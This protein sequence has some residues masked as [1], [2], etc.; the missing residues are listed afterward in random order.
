VLRALD[1]KLLRD[2]W[3]LKAQAFAIAAVMAAGVTMFLAYISTFSSLQLTQQTYYDRY[4]FAHV[5]AQLTR[6]P[7]SLRE[8][9]V[10][11]PGVS[12]VETRVVADVTLDVPGLVEP[13]IGRLVSIPVPQRAMLNDLFVR[14]G[15]YLEEGRPDEVL[16]NEGFALAHD[17]RPGSTLGA[18]I[19]GRRR[20]LHVAGIALSPEYVYTIRPGEVIPDQKRFGVLWID[21]QALAAAFDMEGGFNDVALTV[22]PGASESTVIAELDQI[23]APYGA[24][25]AVPRRLQISNWALSNEL[26]QLRGFGLIVPVIFLSISAFLL[27]VV[28][29]RIVSVQREQIAA[30]KALGYSNREIGTHYTKWSLLVGLAGAALGIAGGSWM[31]SGMILLYNDFF[32]F[33]LLIFTV[34]PAVIV[35][36]T[37]ISLG[38]ATLGAVGAVARAVRLPPAEAM[39]PEPPA[40]YRPSLV[41]RFGLARLLGPAA[42]MVVRNLERQPVRAMTSIVGIALSSSMLVLGLFFLDAMDEMMRLQFEVIQRQDVTVSFVEPR[43]PAAFFEL[44][45]LPGV[46]AVEPMRVVPVRL[47]A[48]H[49]SRQI[50]ISGLTP[51]PRLQR[52]VNTAGDS[53]ALPPEGLVLSRTLADILEVRA[54]QM[55][56]VE[57]L[58]GRRPVRRVPVV[59]LVDEYLGIAAYM[60]L[61]ALHDLLLEAGTMSGAYLL[62]DRQVESALY[63]RLKAMPAVAGVALKQAAIDSF[64]E[65]MG[66]TMGVMIT[67]NVLFA[68]IIAI[69]VVYNA[70]RVSLSERSRELASL[71]VLGFTRAEISAILLGELAVLTVL[72]IPIG[73]GIGYGLAASVVASFETEMYRFPVVV[74]P[75]TYAFAGAVTAIAAALSGLLVRRRLDRLNLVEVLKTRE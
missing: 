2:V 4:R 18:I 17:L 38:A 12:M 28:L 72:A 35:G 41:E 71:R 15:R 58:E 46:L 53:V 50:G 8:R 26:A 11:I 7:L 22:M 44:Q 25:G 37:A 24:L 16:V 75:Q 6:A 13:A 31:G 70:A 74:A 56:D 60:T 20:T 61:D 59:G 54:G 51:E 57:V 5:F 43:A 19:N 14:S 64:N 69:G 30:L 62:V 3:R 39:R 66:E 34:P 10:D 40:R 27:N 32:R 1:R 48:G 67:F 55:I 21:R 63:A 9:L 42:R 52:V 73:L 47:R 68:S 36:A 45:R 29:T 33:P 65:T 49:R 23:L